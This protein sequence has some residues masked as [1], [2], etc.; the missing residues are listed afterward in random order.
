V[1]PYT[2]KDYYQ[3]WMHQ[4]GPSSL[5]VLLYVFHEAPDWQTELRERH[6]L[7]LDIIRLA[8]HLGVEFAFPTQ[9]LHVHGE[10]AAAAP[11]PPPEIP[12]TDRSGQAMRDGRVAVRRLTEHA[13]W[14]R[15]KPGP[16][17]FEHDTEPGED[18]DSQVESRVGGDAG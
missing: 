9:T 4:F 5:D 2:R 6:R 18:D 8:R 3:V 15:E 1:H 14:R 16:Y 13:T 10:D 11:P 12:G 17:R 7:I